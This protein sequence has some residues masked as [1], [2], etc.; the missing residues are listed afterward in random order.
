MDAALVQAIQSQF[1]KEGIPEVRTGDEVEIVQS[2]TEG[3][4]ERQQKFTGL[5]IHTRGNS[6]L[7][8]TIVVRKEMSGVGV[9]KVIPL[10][11]PTIVSI[12]VLRKF[13][14]RRKNIG[15]IRSLRGKS[16]RLK[17]IK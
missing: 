2:F 12:R 6:P 14:V 9:E 4:K 5:V 10:Q 8:H 15:F 17:E 11:C 7:T 3:S 16:A 1:T 13:K